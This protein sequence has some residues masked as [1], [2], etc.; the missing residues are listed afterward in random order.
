MSVMSKQLRRVGIG[1]VIAIVV[2]LVVFEIISKLNQPAQ[3]VISAPSSAQ[4]AEVSL[5]LTPT[6]GG[7]RYAS[8][9]Y[10][11]ALNQTASGKLVTPV[12]AAYEYSYRDVE[13]WNLAIDILLIP[14]GQLTDNNSYQVRKINPQQYQESHVTVNNQS[15]DVMTDKTVSGFSKVAFLIHGQY[16]ATVSLYGDDPSGVGDLQSTFNMVLDTWHWL[17]N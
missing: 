16:Q 8:F 3:G 10:P 7:G 14:S 1:T 4:L 6:P 15:I 11:A 2:L 13:S 17:A 9:N 5:N 12:V